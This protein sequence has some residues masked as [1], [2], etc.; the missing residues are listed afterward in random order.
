MHGVFSGVVL[1]N[2]SFQQQ[3]KGVHIYNI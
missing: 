2:H 1:D 3:A